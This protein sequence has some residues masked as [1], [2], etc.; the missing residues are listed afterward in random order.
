MGSLLLTLED[1]DEKTT[2]KPGIRFPGRVSAA[3]NQSF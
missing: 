3:G 2:A 1:H